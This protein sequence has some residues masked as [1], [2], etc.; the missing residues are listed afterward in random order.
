MVASQAKPWRSAALVTAVLGATA[1]LISTLGAGAAPKPAPAPAGNADDFY[2]F[3][4]A[5]NKFTDEQVSWSFGEKGPYKTFAETKSA[6]AKLGG[7]GRMYFK[8]TDPA[9]GAGKPKEYKDFIEF[10]HGGKGD[11]YGNTTQV[12]EFVIPFT[13]EGIDAAGKSQKVGISES[14]ASI[15]ESFKKEAP[16]EFQG[17]AIGTERIVSP[18]RLKEFQDNGKYANY[19]GPYV[20]EVWKMAE[21]GTTTA[22]GWTF[23]AEGQGVTI[24]KGG[25]TYTMSRKPTTREIFLGT[26]DMG[27][28]ADMCSAWN[29]HVFAEP[30]DWRSPDKYYKAE[31]MNFYAAFWHKHTVNGQAYGFCYD[32]FHHQAAY[33]EMHPAKKLIVTVYWDTPPAKN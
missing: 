15:F 13:I 16:V 10:T 28:S 18:M 12:D 2:F 23:K 17:C 6:P 19:F 24:S 21:K 33:F 9:G 8:V 1:L 22:G 29:R 25:K 11:W 14:R 31:P 27:K 30:A 26:A 7:G 5:T 3:V 20:D 32:D 4:N